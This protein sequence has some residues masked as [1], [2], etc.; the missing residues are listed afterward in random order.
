MA[1]LTWNLLTS[2]QLVPV[3]VGGKCRVGFSREL[4][5][6]LH[7]ELFLITIE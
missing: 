7:G 2:G 3:A 1:V 4:M 5:L 6:P